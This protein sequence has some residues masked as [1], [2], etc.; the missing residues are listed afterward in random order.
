MIW[1]D[2][3]PEVDAVQPPPGTLGHVLW[4]IESFV[5]EEVSAGGS[6]PGT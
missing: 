4:A 5:G 2:G 3:G 1:G 6:A